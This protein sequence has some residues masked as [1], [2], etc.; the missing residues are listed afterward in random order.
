M[1]IMRILEIE[2]IGWKVESVRLEIRIS[3]LSGQTTDC[4]WKIGGTIACVTCF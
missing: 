3:D 4:H 2:V 1:K